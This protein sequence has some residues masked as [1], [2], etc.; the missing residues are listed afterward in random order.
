MGI[1]P[2][3]PLDYPIDNP[4]LNTI[5][6]SAQDAGLAVVHHSFAVGYPGFRDMWDSPF[7]GRSASHPW[8]AMRFVAAITGSGMMERYPELNFAILESGFGWLPFWARQLDEQADYVGYV[9]A[10]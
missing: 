10:P 6:D 2:Q 7:M 1:Q 4:D 8:G 9:N 5:R 3:L